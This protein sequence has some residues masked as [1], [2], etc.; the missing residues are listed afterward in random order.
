MIHSNHGI[1]NHSKLEQVLSI[2]FCLYQTKRNPFVSLPKRNY[3]Y[4]ALPFN[5]KQNSF[6]NTFKLKEIRSQWNFSVNL[7]VISNLFLWVAQWND[8]AARFQLRSPFE[9]SV[10]YC[11][12]IYKGFQGSLNWF[13]PPLF[14]RVTILPTVIRLIFLKIVVEIWKEE[15][16]GRA[17]KRPHREILIV[18]TLFLLIWHQTEFRLAPNQW[19]KCNYDQNVV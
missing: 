14:T 17:R 8:V 16:R 12:K 13:P 2:S 19:E 11:R 3:H 15:N 10:P 9:P 18:I 4:E 5:S 6:L 1:W 7:K